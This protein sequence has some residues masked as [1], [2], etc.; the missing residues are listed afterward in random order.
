MKMCSRFISLIILIF[1]CNCSSDDNNPGISVYS[2]SFDFSQSLDGWEA[3]FTDLPSNKDDSSFYELTFAYTDLPANLGAKKAIMLSGAN[4]SDDLFMFIKRK[5]S[6]LTPN[7]SY[8][9]V[10]EVEL[11]SNAQRG[12]VG[13]GGSPGESVF[14]KAGASELE[15][16]KVAQNNQYVL[17]IDKG[18]QSTN[19]NDAITLGDIAIP[20]TATHYTLITRTNASPYTSP[21]NQTFI[22]QSN[23]EGEIWLVI[24]TDSGFEGT[25]T[26][27]Y[28]KVNVVFSASN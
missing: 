13:I 7:T 18:N 4:H 20:S 5:I 12:S 23:S 19:G 6:G 25:T 17:N 22:A 9:I 26:V 24:G 3:D 15:P 11:A 21:Y 14:L 10:F 1:A 8:N 16:K 2:A 28:T 27:Y